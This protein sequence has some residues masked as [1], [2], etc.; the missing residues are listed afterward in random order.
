MRRGED[1]LGDVGF[2][3]TFGEW[4]ARI[5]CFLNGPPCC[6]SC[7]L[8]RSILV[9]VGLGDSTHLTSSAG[10]A[11]KANTASTL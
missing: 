2:Y 7:F 3:V 10:S 9:W 6:S 1:E 4:V 5:G 8:P 11:V